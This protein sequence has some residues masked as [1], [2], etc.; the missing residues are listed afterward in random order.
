MGTAGDGVYISKSPA[1]F[2]QVPDLHPDQAAFT[3]SVLQIT[4]MSLLKL[5]T[6][7]IV[8]RLALT[9]IGTNILSGSYEVHVTGT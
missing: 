4:F 5:Q 2:M 6:S 8:H 1:E 3:G 7:L 9:V